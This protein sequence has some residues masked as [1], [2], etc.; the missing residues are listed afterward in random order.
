MGEITQYGFE[1]S[2][3]TADRPDN[4]EEGQQYFNEDLGVW[5][6]RNAAGTPAWQ[7]AYIGVKWSMAAHGSWQLANDGAFTNGGGIVGDV[8]IAV[9]IDNTTA[10]SD[11]GGAGTFADIAAT[12]NLSSWNLDYQLSA[13]AGLENSGVDADGST[14][15]DAI[16]FGHSVPFCEIGFD[17]NPVGVMDNKVWRWEY[18]NGTQWNQIP[19]A[20]FFDNTDDVSQDGEESFSR[21]GAVTFIPPSDWATTSVNSAT[22]YWIRARVVALGISTTPLMNDPAEPVM[23]TPLDGFTCPHGGTI[24]GIRCSNAATTLHSGTAVKWILM[25]F[26]TG[27]HS[28]ELEWAVSQQ[29]DS[30][31][32]LTLAVNTGD[33][34]GVLITQ[35]DSGNDDPTNV[36]LELDVS[37][38]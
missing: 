18:Y 13:D 19:T 33:E 32:S 28:G 37:A 11:S 9:N 30:F 14:D 31:A 4:V 34:L 22:K 23:V 2:G 24:T 17:L 12:S 6:V 36:M 16:Y 3:T 7:G 1:V 20:S 5:Q 38:P 26:T 15:G 21:N 27:A 25:N 29:Q 35:E 10:F 8:S